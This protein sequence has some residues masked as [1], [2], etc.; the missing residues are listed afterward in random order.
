M[1]RNLVPSN[2][3]AAAFRSYATDYKWVLTAVPGE[4]VTSGNTTYEKVPIGTEVEGMNILG[5]ILF[6]MTFGIALRKL[7]PDGEQLIRFFS[8][9]NDATMILVSWIMWR[10]ACKEDW[11]IYLKHYREVLD[12]LLS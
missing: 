10:S 2:L 3:I 7:G 5:L 6:A 9:F 1:E 4:N 12:I 8:A 11:I